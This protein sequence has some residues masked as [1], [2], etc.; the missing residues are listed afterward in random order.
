M[1]DV[2]FGTRLSVCL[3]EGARLIGGPLNRGFT[4]TLYP[5]DCGQMMGSY[6]VSR[7][8]V[9]EGVNSQKQPKIYVASCKGNPK[10]SWILNSL[11][12]TGFAILG[13]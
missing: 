4:V 9:R 11:P 8:P 2:R 7:V 10:Q 5:N 6:M 13:F 3:I 1:S 12:C